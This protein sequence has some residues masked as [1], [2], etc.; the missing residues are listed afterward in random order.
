M[1]L[2]EALFAH[3]SDAGTF[4]GALVGKRI[5]PQLIPQGV[6]RPALAYQRVG[7]GERMLAH[8]G[9]TGFGR[10]TIQITV[11]AKEYRDAKPVAQAVRKDLN[12]FKGVLGG[13]GGVDVGRCAIENEIDGDEEFDANTVRMDF[14]F[15]YQEQ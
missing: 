14:A 1:T 10:A 13:V 6:A 5:Y 9:P 7:R 4:T 15:I 2:E 3:L 8:D 12:G 11:Q